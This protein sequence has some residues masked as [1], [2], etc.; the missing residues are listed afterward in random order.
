MCI[1]GSATV[2]LAV[3]RSRRTSSLLA[4]FTFGAAM[5]RHNR[6]CRADRATRDRYKDDLN[7][8]PF[9]P[10]SHWIIWLFIWVG[11]DRIQTIKIVKNA[12]FWNVTSCGSCKNRR[13]GGTYR[14]LQLLVTANVPS[15][16]NFSIWWWER[17]VPP[18]R[19]FLQGPHLRR[20]HPSSINMLS[21]LL[22]FW[23]LSIV[24]D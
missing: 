20:W 21:D 7:D 16:L 17:Y 2:A 19:L 8:D 11:R 15:S 9:H 3:Q 6:N 12:V 13:F 22:G 5:A 23:T 1:S 10:E 18:K 4:H 24:R 14:T